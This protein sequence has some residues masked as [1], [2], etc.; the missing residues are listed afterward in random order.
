VLN[1]HSIFRFVAVGE[2]CAESTFHLPVK[3]T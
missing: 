1:A 3:Q 2:E